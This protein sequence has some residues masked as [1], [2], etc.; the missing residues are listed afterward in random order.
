MDAQSIS[1][2]LNPPAKEETKKSGD[3]L[4][5]D[6]FLKL[7]TSQLKYQNPLEPMNDQEFVGQMTQ[8][9]SLEQ[10]QNMNS[11]L[12]QNA[13][14]NMLL[15]QTINNTM[16]TSLIG[17]EVTADSN[18]IGITSGEGGDITFQSTDFALN[19]SITISDEK[20][21]VVRTVQVNNLKP[22]SNSVHWDGKDDQGNNA[23]S[24]NYT[25][26]IDLKD[27]NGQAVSVSNLRTGTV[28]SVKYVDGQAYLLVDGS[29]IP[30]AQIREVKPGKA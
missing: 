7:L 10:L 15:S 17:K 2:I 27:T 19:G 3:I 24:G 25:Y 11:T 5:K 12:A 28:E 18:A 22:G 9:S 8:F 29:Y 13:Q 1:S 23:P 30:L 6:A 26:Q 4:G 14:W 21:N 16:A 20:G